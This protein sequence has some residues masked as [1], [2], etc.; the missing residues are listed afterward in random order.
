MLKRI[1]ACMLIVVMILGLGMVNVYAT[2]EIR[3]YPTSSEEYGKTV[4]FY[5]ENGWTVYYFIFQEVLYIPVCRVGNFIYDPKS[6]GVPYDLAIYAEKGDVVLHL[7][8]AYDSGEVTDL[9]AL[10]KAM[11]AEENIPTEFITISGDTDIDGKLTVSDVLNIQ[12]TLAKID[13]LVYDNPYIEERLKVY[14][15]DY[16]LDDKVTLSDAIALQLHLARKV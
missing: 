9:E 13:K 6:V 10:T 2:E 15:R 11:E 16:D 12:K 5:E 7:D 14:T 8:E 1:T 4:I 3:P